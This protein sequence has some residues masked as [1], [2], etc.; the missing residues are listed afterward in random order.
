M[1]LTCQD[2]FVLDS[3]FECVKINTQTECNIAGCEYC[4]EDNVCAM[5]LGGFDEYFLTE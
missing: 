2:G 4:I 3:T 1:C 5:C